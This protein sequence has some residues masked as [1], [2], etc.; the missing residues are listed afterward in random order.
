MAPTWDVAAIADSLTVPILLAHGRHDYVV[1][2]RLWADIVPKLPAAT[3][4]LFESSGHQ[5]FVEEPDHFTTVVADWLR[6]AR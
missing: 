6:V 5:P 3:F 1:P 4:H 2:Y